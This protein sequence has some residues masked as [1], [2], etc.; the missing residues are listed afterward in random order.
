M[1][2]STALPPK[3]RSPSRRWPKFTA[4]DGNHRE[5]ARE[6]LLHEN[7]EQALKFVLR[8]GVDG[9][10]PGASLTGLL[11]D[12]SLTSLFSGWLTSPQDHDGTVSWTA[13]KGKRT[14]IDHLVGYPPP[15]HTHTHTHTHS[16]RSSWPP[17]A[18]NSGRHLT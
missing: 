2:A 9:L 18:M 1:P 16:W 10:T 4:V 7:A 13:N 3:R 5:I 11:R 17:T 6:M 8:G 15:P 12:V 14:N